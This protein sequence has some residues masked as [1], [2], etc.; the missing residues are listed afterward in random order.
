MPFECHQPQTVAEKKITKNCG[1]WRTLSGAQALRKSHQGEEKKKRDREK[2]E[3]VRSHR[4]F[5]RRE[6][7]IKGKLQ[8]ESRSFGVDKRE[9]K[10]G[11]ILP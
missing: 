10:S 7:Q 4:V 6:F 2:K 3:R 11:I 1:Y 5:G 8:P 9:A